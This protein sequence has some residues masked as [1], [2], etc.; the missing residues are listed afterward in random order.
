MMTV[1]INLGDAPDLTVAANVLEATTAH[2]AFLAV[3]IGPA[4]VILPDVDTA[5]R[6]AAALHLA[7]D[8]LEALPIGRRYRYSAPGA[9][10]PAPAPPSLDL[11]HIQF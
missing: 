5:R 4:S 8:R 10:T 6:L 9:T 7:C 1:S 3:D 11:P 2:D